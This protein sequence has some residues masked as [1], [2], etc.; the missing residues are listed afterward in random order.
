MVYLN[1]E[2]N[3]LNAFTLISDLLFVQIPGIPQEEFDK[4]PKEPPKELDT[5]D[6]LRRAR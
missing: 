4:P 6:L 3:L 2:I 5:F 1:I